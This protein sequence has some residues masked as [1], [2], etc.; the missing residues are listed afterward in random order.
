MFTLLN[1]EPKPKPIRLEVLDP[2][3]QKFKPIEIKAVCSAIYEIKLHK[4]CG[5]SGLGPAHLKFVKKGW[6]DFI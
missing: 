6:K 3:G 4:S 2:V 5:P 1:P